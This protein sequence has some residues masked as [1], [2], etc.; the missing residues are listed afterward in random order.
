MGI[1]FLDLTDALT[2]GSPRS[3]HVAAQLREAGLA[4]GFF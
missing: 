4:S 3:A 2:P 1:P